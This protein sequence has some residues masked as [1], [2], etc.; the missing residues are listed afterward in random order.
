MILRV[1]CPD[2]RRVLRT[3][4]QWCSPPLVTWAAP[5]CPVWIDSPDNRHNTEVPSNTHFYDNS[6]QWKNLFS[7]E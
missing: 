4:V 5:P 7:F 1:Y 2:D 6:P 3:Y